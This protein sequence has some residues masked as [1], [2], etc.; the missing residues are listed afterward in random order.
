MPIDPLSTGS[1][2]GAGGFAALL[3][4]MFQSWLKRE[5]EK[6][7]NDKIDD[8]QKTV[9]DFEL[10]VA[11]NHATKEELSL[12]ISKIDKSIELLGEKIDKLAEKIK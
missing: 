12:S 8:L 1:A 6:E 10:Y 11:R 2:A 4:N 5:R 9:Q 3:V 7:I